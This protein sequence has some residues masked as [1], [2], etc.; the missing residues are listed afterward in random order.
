MRKIFAIIIIACVS[1]YTMQAKNLVL[2]ENP[3]AAC[4]EAWQNYQKANALWKTGWGLFGAGL[5]VGFIGGVMYPLGAFG[6]SS[7]PTG[8]PAARAKGLSGFTFLLVGSAMIITSVPCLAVGQTRRKAALKAYNENCAPDQ[9]VVS[10]YL[11]S[12]S[13][14]LGI[15]MKF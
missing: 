15:A 5:G 7:S 6:N 2:L 8:N 11:Q 14:G 10:F 4:A 9:P 12:S 3:N 13:N 1:V